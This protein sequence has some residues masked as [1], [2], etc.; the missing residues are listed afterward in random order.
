MLELLKWNTKVEGLH[1]LSPLFHRFKDRSPRKHRIHQGKLY[2]QQYRLATDFF[3]GECRN[4]SNF[5][6]GGQT[7]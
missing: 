5:I 7:T 2:C 1:H 6:L 3:E 4:I